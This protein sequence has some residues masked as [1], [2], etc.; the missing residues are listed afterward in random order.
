MWAVIP[1]FIALLLLVSAP[2]PI[3]AQVPVVGHLGQTS[4]EQGQP[5]MSRIRQHLKELGHEEG[6]TFLLETRWAGG[7]NSRYPA[8]ARELMARR[9]AVIFAGCGGPLVAIREISRDVPV[10]SGCLDPKN[11]YGAIASLAR[12]GGQTTGFLFL[13]P[14]SAGKR[15]QLLKELVPTLSRVGVLHD[16]RA[17]WSTYHQEMDHVAARLGLSFTKVPV[18]RTDD[19]EGAFALALRQK[20]QALMVFPSTVILTSRSRIAALAVTHRLPTVFDNHLFV[21][22]GGLLSYGPDW[23]GFGARVIA[24]YVDKILKGA[25]PGDLPVQQ[26]T[27]FESVINLKTAR[28]LGL[29]VQQSF[30]AR[31]DKVIQ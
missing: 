17:D 20:A 26:P 10:V 21:E 14:E 7:D 8:L 23:F 13:S 18:T 11:Y 25:R 28:A 4:S 6:R 30:L 5:Y 3:W 27:H 29:D 24:D 15:L 12:P 1:C 16:P 31:V 9:P 22:E 19:L 2:A